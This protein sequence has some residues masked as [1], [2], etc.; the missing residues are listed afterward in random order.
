MSVTY[1]SF[2][3]HCHISNK[4]DVQMNIIHTVTNRRNVKH[5]STCDQSPKLQEPDS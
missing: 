5:T 1:N 4:T 3:I 2:K